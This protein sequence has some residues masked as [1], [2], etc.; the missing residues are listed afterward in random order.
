[1]RSHL[2]FGAVVSTLLSISGSAYA[3]GENA[4]ENEVAERFPNASM[5]DIVATP[6]VA[7]KGGALRVDWS[8]HMENETARGF[9]KV[10][11]GGDVVRLKVLHHKTYKQKK[12]SN[13][14]FD[15]FYYDEHLGKWR[16][17]DGEICHSCTPENGF[18]AHHSHSKK[19]HK[20]SKLEHQME[21]HLRNQLSQDDINSLNAWAE[22]NR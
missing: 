20:Q 12:S 6:S 19:Y 2:L 9:C 11:K 1:M 14:D 5:A 13:D 17:D 15:G 10:T 21:D 22:K 7:I 4:C 18:P 16:T 8:I 3:T